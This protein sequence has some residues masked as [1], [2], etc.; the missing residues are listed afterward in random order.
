M[1]KWIIIASAVVTVGSIIGLGCDEWMVGAPC[2][3]ETDKGEFRKEIADKN[4]AIET[5]AL[6][7]QGDTPMVCMTKTK[8]R[9]SQRQAEEGE[10]LS[11]FQIYEGRSGYGTQTKYSFCSCRCKDAD[12][13]QYDRNSDK[14]DDLC[15]CPPNT[16]CESVLNKNVQGAP[17]NIKGSYCIP[18]CIADGCEHHTQGEECKPSSDSEEPWKW[19]CAPG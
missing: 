19:H 12:G 2:V 3:P 9:D 4:Y 15:E 6:Q 10:E 7:C 13:E 1:K 17:D 16:I 8:V 18:N 5:R 11:D 14:Y